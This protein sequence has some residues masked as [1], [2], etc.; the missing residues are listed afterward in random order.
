MGEE[1]R[2]RGNG[3]ESLVGN[4]E[5]KTDLR[6]PSGRRSGRGPYPATGEMPNAFL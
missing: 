3:G 6:R 2:F 4:N 5:S 1:R